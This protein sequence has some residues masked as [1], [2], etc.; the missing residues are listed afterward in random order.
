[1]TEVKYAEPE[2]AKHYRPLYKGTI[3]INA[4]FDREKGNKIIDDGLADLVAFGKPFISN[5]DLAERFAKDLELTPWDDS[6]FYSGG[7]KGYTDYSSAV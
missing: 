2:I 4:G 3:I 5:P 7:A 1:V 6:T